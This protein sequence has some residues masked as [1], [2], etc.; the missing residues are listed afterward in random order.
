MIMNNMSL[1][2]RETL[3]EAPEKYAGV[4]LALRF[5][6]NCVMGF[7][8]G[9]LVTKI[10]A[11]ASLMATTSICSAGIA[12]ALFVPGQWYL[13]GFGLLGAGELFYVYYLN[14]IVSSSAAAT[15]FPAHVRLSLDELLLSRARLRFV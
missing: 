7:G 12:W 11:R 8:L 13:L 5:G 14:Y 3:G 1:Y 10:H 2:A 6:F 9:W 4:Q 15:D